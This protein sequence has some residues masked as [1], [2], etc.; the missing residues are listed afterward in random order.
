M[1][2]MAPTEMPPPPLLLSHTGLPGSAS[3]KKLPSASTTAGSQGGAGGS[4]RQ[5]RLSR[6]TKQVLLG[7]L[8]EHGASLQR[9]AHA[10]RAAAA[11]TVPARLPAGSTIRSSHASCGH[12]IDSHTSLPSGACPERA[13]AVRVSKESRRREAGQTCRHPSCGRVRQAAAA[14]TAP[15]PWQTAGAPRL[16]AHSQDRPS[17]RAFVRHRVRVGQG[18]ADVVHAER[19]HALPPLQSTSRAEARVSGQTA[20]APKCRASVQVP[21]SLSLLPPNP[22]TCFKVMRHS[23]GQWGLPAWSSAAPAGLAA[24]AGASVGNPTTSCS[25]SLSLQLI[26]SSCM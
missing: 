14:G 21:P 19:R 11:C 5:R 24:G 23:R 8:D 13:R 1:P 2:T 9:N 3:Q 6:R 16:R 15:A 17:Q 7:A 18:V 25:F 10:A 20:C 26:M 22:C 4:A 12:R